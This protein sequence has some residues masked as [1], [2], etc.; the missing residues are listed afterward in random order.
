MATNKADKVLSVRLLGHADTR[1]DAAYNMSLSQERISSV[2]RYF[3]LLNIK[4]RNT[5][6]RTC[7]D[8]LT[9]SKN[10]FT[11]SDVKGKVTV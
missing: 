1:G 5:H 8:A 9:M 2:T 11:T 3:D 7:K 10:R 4:D 6:L